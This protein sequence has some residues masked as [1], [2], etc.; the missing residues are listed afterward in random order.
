[1]WANAW[2]LTRTT[3]KLLSK[4]SYTISIYGSFHISGSD[5]RL[6]RIRGEKERNRPVVTAVIGP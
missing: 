2:P 4:I 5:G 6:F 3:C 1:M